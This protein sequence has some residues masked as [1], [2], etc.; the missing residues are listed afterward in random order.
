MGVVNN[1]VIFCEGTLDKDLINQLLGNLSNQ[2]TIVPT[3]GKFNWIFG[4]C[5]AKLLNKMPV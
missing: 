1:K 3:G 2:I 4:T 5:Y